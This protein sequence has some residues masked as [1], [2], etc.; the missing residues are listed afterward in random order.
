M[1]ET[2]DRSTSRAVERRRTLHRYPEPAW[3]E[4]YTTS[5]LVDYVEEIGV[6]EVVVGEDAMV[7]EKRL[8]V[9]VSDVLDEWRERARNAG[10]RE[11]VLEATA[12]GHTGLLAVLERGPGPVV[13][14]RVDIDA[15]PFAESE[16]SDHAP[17]AE[18]FRAEHDDAMHAC[19]HDA[20]MSMGL[21]VLEAIKA[22][23]FSG[24]FKL[25]FQPSEELLGGGG[26]MA[27]TEYVDAI[28]RLFAVHIGLGAPSGTIV[29][30]VDKQL[31]IR[32]STATFRGESA[33]AGLAP[34]DGRNA[35]QAMA[36]AITNLYGIARHEDDLTRV[37]VGRAEAGSASNIV[38][39]SATIEL[40]VRAGANHVLDHMTEE[41]DRILQSAAEMH[42]C[43]LETTVTGRAPRADSSDSLREIVETVAGKH[44]GV[45]TVVPR[46]GFGASEDATYFMQR[47]VDNGGDA[48][49]V[50]VGTDLPSGHHTPRFDIDEE[51]I[52]I[53]IDVLSRSILAAAAESEPSETGD[54]V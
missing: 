49:H 6:D 18:G 8:G 4:F 53:G 34:Q 46:T 3:R 29:A 25:F 20:H 23:D 12:G 47:V 38:A 41:A 48:T 30:G 33:H 43:D 7:S 15:L 50:L 40:E 1:S 16:G 19:G 42:E 52:G 14:L 21:G 13:G 31:A 35:M 32:Q 51:S 54:R 22:S 45:D 24:T 26:A 17:A 28:D 2:T 5:R 27:A 44:D 10:A 37:N 36:T 11:D 9:P 39:D